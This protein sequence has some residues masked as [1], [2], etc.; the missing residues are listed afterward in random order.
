MKREGNEILLA[1]PY[2]LEDR[3][4]FR[5]VWNGASIH[6][7]AVLAVLDRVLRVPAVIARALAGRARLKFTGRAGELA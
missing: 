6:H 2:I 5:C 3:L 7:V 4:E 1:V